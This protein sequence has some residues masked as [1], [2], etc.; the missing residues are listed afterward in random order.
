MSVMKDHVWA[1]LLEEAEELG[2]D[3]VGYQQT[4]A[5]LLER[6]VLERKTE[7]AEEKRKEDEYDGPVFE[8]G[9]E[10]I[11]QVVGAVSPDQGDLENMLGFHPA[12]EV[13]GAQH[14]AVRK[15]SLDYGEFVLAVIPFSRESAIFVTKLREAMMWAN[16]AIACN[17]VDKLYVEDAQV[18]ESDVVDDGESDLVSDTTYVTK[19][20]GNDPDQALHPDDDTHQEN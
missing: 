6:R 5:H 7:L 12:T 4:S 15:A 19:E 17:Q 3:T 16:A 9:E 14:D 1:R 8:F 20:N 18:L 10:F 11:K 13:T 2:L